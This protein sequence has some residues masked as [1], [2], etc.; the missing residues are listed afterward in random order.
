MNHACFP[1]RHAQERQSKKS[2][3]RI[4]EACI[5]EVFR[6]EHVPL[7]GLTFAPT[8]RAKALSRI[9]WSRNKEPRATTSGA[10]ACDH[11]ERGLQPSSWHRDGQK[12]EGRFR[13]PRESYYPFGTGFGFVMNLARLVGTVKVAAMDRINN[14]APSR[15]REGINYHGSFGVQVENNQTK[16]GGMKAIDPE[17]RLP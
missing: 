12:N 6:E 13:A 9:R 7:H 16:G 11:Q 2:S 1:T 3:P 8:S 10:R 5:H 14:S 15:G 17:W 4:K